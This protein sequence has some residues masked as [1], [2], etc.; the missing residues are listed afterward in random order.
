MNGNGVIIWPWKEEDEEPA[1]RLILRQET[2]SGLLQRVLRRGSHGSRCLTLI[3]LFDGEMKGLQ[4]RVRRTGDGTGDES[5]EL[6]EGRSGRSLLDV[7]VCNDSL[8]RDVVL[9]LL[10]VHPVFHS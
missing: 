4:I 6:A 2:T 7:D 5:G 3:C 10:R 8:P 1:G 9:Q